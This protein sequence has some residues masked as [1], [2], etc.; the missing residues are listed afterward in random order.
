MAGL[1]MSVAAAGGN[2]YNLT[3]LGTADWIVYPS[4]STVRKSGGAGISLAHV[5]T[6]SD[7]TASPAGDTATW[8]DG[9]GT[10]SGSTQNCIFTNNSP[11]NGFGYSATFPAD[12]SQRTA[13]F[14]VGAYAASLRITATLSDGSAAQQVDTSVVWSSGGGR[15]A[16][17][18]VT[19]SAASSGQTM[20]IS[21]TQNSAVAGSP[22]VSM[23][24]A[25][26]TTAAAQ[27]TNVIT[28]GAGSSA[29]RGRS[30]RGRR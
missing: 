10:A 15:L 16:L 3:T 19:Y 12:T 9:S 21:S 11:G 23:Q 18:S 13:Y 30:R 1:S 7:G 22:N 17:V 14:L 4:T 25:A 2:T 6:F 26:L 8:S 20:T 28:V 27:Q 29:K 24:F 5:G